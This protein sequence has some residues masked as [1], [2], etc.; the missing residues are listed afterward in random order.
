MDFPHS[1]Q[2]LI[3]VLRGEFEVPQCLF[4]K[5]RREESRTQRSVIA[6]G[7][8]VVTARLAMRHLR[9]PK[10]GAIRRSEIYLVR[11]VLAVDQKPHGQLHVRAQVEEVATENSV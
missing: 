2:H 11:A 8:R 4:G 1:E 9:L 3:A 5:A 6:L 10:V 7:F